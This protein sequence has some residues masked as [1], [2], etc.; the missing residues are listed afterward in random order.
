MLGSRAIFG[1]LRA[2]APPSA[3]VK[4]AFMIMFF[5]FVVVLK[6]TPRTGDFIL[7]RLVKYCKGKKTFVKKSLF[8]V[9]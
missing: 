1:Q 2:L 8:E 5:N 6:K 7:P 9:A 4:M 3:G